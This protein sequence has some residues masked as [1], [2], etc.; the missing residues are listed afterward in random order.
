MKILHPLKMAK[1]ASILIENGAEDE[2]PVQTD[3]IKRTLM[4][5]VEDQDEDGL[6]SDSARK[7]ANEPPSPVKEKPENPFMSKENKAFI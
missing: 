2:S 1:Q 6:A 5:T 3:R 7:I 4:M